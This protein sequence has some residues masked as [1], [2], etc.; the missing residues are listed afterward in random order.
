MQRRPRSLY[1]IFAAV[2]MMVA[3]ILVYWFFAFAYTGPG[4]VK[5]EIATDKQFY[6]LGEEIQFRVHVYNPQLWRAT[7]PSRVDY[8][9][10]DEGLTKHITLASPPPSFPG[11]SRTLYDT[12]VWDQ[13]TGPGGNRTQALPGEY[14]LTVSFDGPIEYGNGGD[15]TVKIC[16]PTTKQTH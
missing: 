3:G 4:P 16:L 9:I 12:Y 8:R 13:K 11:K 10:G 6:L 14:L 15:C 1:L 5:I 7:Y 2:T